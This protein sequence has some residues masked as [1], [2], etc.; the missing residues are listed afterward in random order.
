MFETLQA[1]QEIFGGRVGHRID[2]DGDRSG[3][4]RGGGRVA[5]EWDRVGQLSGA[6]GERDAA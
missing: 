3:P 1:E 4:A 2:Q 6:R 5:D